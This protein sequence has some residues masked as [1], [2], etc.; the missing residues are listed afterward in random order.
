MLME[1]NTPVRTILVLILSF[2]ITACGQLISNA[3]QQFA[4]DLSATLLEQND[5]A[6][7]KQAIPAYLIMVS[8]MVRGDPDNPALLISASR[9]YGASASA[10]VRKVATV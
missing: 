7:V 8:S 2:A 10:F 5:P 9:L 1:M 6:M 3:K 4:D